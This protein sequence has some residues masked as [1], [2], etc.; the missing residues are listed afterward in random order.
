MKLFLLNSFAFKKKKKIKRHP[1]GALRLIFKVARGRGLLCRK[2]ECATGNHNETF[3][4]MD[5]LR[6]GIE[7]VVQRKRLS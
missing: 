6:S 4:F 5:F 2:I 3:L 1:S 7:Y